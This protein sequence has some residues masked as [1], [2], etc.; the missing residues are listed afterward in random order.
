MTAPLLV[1]RPEPGATATV[2]A[3]RALGR[4]AIAAPLF[5]TRAIAWTPP[6]PLPAAVLMTSA[7]AARHGGEGLAALAGLKLYAV[8]EA[9]AQAARAAGFA[10][11]VSGDGGVD[12]ILARAAADGVPSLL[13]LAGREHR[14]P[15]DPPL[16]IVRRIVYA[17]DAVDRLPAEARA[18][19]PDVIALLHSAR[20]AATFARLLD[21]AGIARATIAIAAIS[22][23]AR[24]AAGTGWRATTVAGQP[25]D[26][27]LLAAAAKL[28]DQ[29]G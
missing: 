19:L 14:P 15:A 21:A 7:S 8:G 20:A 13:H 23:A 9:T 18:V 12:A 16:P 2:T 1:L 10:D 6:D 26:A 24:D 11:I 27:A 17:A 28:C 5:V 22:P 25:R 4:E 29:G 3:A